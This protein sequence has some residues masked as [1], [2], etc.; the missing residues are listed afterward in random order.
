M[1]HCLAGA[2]KGS[3]PLQILRRSVDQCASLGLQDVCGNTAQSWQG[4]PLARPR[5][6]PPAVDADRH[7]ADSASQ[8]VSPVNHSQDMEP[9]R[10]T[11]TV[12][13]RTVMAGPAPLIRSLQAPQDPMV[14]VL[15]VK[16]ARKISLSQHPSTKG[17]RAPRYLRAGLGDFPLHQHRSMDERA[18]F[19]RA[20]G[21][22]SPRD[23]HGQ[24]LAVE[25]TRGRC[26]SPGAHRGSS[27]GTWENS[28]FTEAEHDVEFP[29]YTTISG[30]DVAR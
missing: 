24:R 30:F 27:R 28:L 8:T 17:F 3:W 22:P 12:P 9:S 4:V 10:S 18:P 5:C 11:C 26:H 6:I 2:T 20:Q 1:V 23:P 7:R 13:W 19:N 14:T 29:Y 21:A 15:P 16:H 25:P